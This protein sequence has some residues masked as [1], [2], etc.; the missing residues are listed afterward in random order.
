MNTG[1]TRKTPSNTKAG[2]IKPYP[3]KLSFNVGF[4]FIKLL[5]NQFPLR[6][7]SATDQLFSVMQCKQG[8]YSSHTFPYL[9]FSFIDCCLHFCSSGICNFLDIWIFFKVACVSCCL[10]EGT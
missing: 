9:F 6:S 7:E 8:G 2:D 1:M 4:L 10:L 3:I 5:L